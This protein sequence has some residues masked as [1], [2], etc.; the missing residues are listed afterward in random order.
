VS[1]REKQKEERETRIA[2]KLFVAI[3]SQCNCVWLGLA[4]AEG[5]ERKRDKPENTL[6]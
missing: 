6:L 2:K 3:F 5:R 4:I 1:G